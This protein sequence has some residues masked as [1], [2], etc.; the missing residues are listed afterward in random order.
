VTSPGSC[1]RYLAGRR[2]QPA[3][4]L[5]DPLDR[6]LDRD[7]LAF[8]ADTVAHAGEGK[9]QKAGITVDEPTSAVLADRVAAR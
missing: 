6:G 3:G 1:P 9:S 5:A 7:N 4:G 8:A 2:H